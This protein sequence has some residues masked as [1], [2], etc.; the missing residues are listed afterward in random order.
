MIATKENPAPR[1]NAESRADTKSL[2]AKFH[3]TKPAALLDLAA[4]AAYA[5]RK[6]A[7]YARALVGTAKGLLTTAEG[8][9]Q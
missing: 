2:T 9:A 8:G 3:T 5:T 6:A 7:A 4:L 1:A